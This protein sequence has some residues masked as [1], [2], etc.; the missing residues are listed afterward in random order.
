LSKGAWQNKMLMAQ[1]VIVCH[2]IIHAAN[3]I[4]HIKE[5]FTLP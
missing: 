2:Y 3:A 1:A 4:M 5:T